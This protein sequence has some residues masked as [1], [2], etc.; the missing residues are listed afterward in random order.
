M[1]YRLLSKHISKTQMAAFALASLIGMLLLVSGIQFYRD[2]QPLLSGDDGI[3]RPEYVVVS[4]HVSTMS[5]LFGSDRQGF[6]E[7]EISDLASQDFVETLAPF[8]SAACRVQGYIDLPGGGTYGTD[9]FLESVPDEYVDVD[10]TLWQ[11]TATNGDLTE[12]MPQ[13]PI[14]LPR[15]YLNMYNFGFAATRGLPRLSETAMSMVPVRLVMSIQGRG[16]MIN[17]RVVAFSSRLNTI[18]VP[19]TFMNVV[20]ALCQDN[21]KV[22]SRLI[23]KVPNPA[24][25]RLEKYLEAHNLQTENNNQEAGRLAWF[26]RAMLAV[27]LAIG[28]LICALA[29]YLLVV[30]IYLLVQKNQDRL[31]TLRLIGYSVNQVS[32]PYIVLA[33]V[34]NAGVCAVALVLLLLVRHF[35]LTVIADIYPD[36]T[37]VS[38]LLTIAMALA[39]L[40]A[41]CATNALIILRRIRALL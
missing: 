28:G 8:T 3:L 12:D 33:T 17:A 25:M 7:D 40:V 37:G 20:N 23:L 9:M 27:C 22:P 2:L 41:I 14:V 39:L 18:L 29:C 26:L 30:S 38:P 5:S 11:W 34:L 13:V 32:H 31:F 10:K 36:F 1:L 21:K 6:G 24:D 4:K 35:Y 19:G 15:T 16:V